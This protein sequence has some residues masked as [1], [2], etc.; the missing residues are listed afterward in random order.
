LINHTP[1]GD[2]KSHLIF[3]WTLIVLIELLGMHGWLLCLWAHIW[4]VSP[5]PLIGSS[6]MQIDKLDFELGEEP[7]H[8][9]EDFVMGHIISKRG[10]EVDKEK[11]ELIADLPPPGIIKQICSFLGHA[12]FNCRFIKD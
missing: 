10:I 4:T 7:H 1:N 3:W 9:Q 6:T 12:G 8:V 5:Q 2:F 11:V